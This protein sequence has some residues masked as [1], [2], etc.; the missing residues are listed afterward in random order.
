MTSGRYYGLQ[1]GGYPKSDTAG[2]DATTALVAVAE[3]EDLMVAIKAQE[4]AEGRIQA[5]D[6][7]F[8]LKVCSIKVD[9][10]TWFQINGKGEIAVTPEDI[11]YSIDVQEIKSL[12]AL[13]ATNV[14]IGYAF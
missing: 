14:N 4:V 11:R 3:D 7:D 6:D 9:S 5:T 12:V 13:G 2:A 8:A 10:T 1:S